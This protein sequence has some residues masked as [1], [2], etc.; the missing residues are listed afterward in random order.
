MKNDFNGIRASARCF[1]PGI[2]NWSV[3]WNEARDEVWLSGP[4]AITMLKSNPM[5]G[6]SLADQLRDLSDEVERIEIQIGNIRT[7]ALGCVPR[8]DQGVVDEK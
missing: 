4:D 8:R 2:K 6:A 3:T 1:V 5:S 7:A